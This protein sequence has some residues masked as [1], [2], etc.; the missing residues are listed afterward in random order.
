LS[1]PERS[2]SSGRSSPPER[3]SSAPARAAAPVEPAA[4]PARPAHQHRRTS[5][6]DHEGGPSKP[7]SPSPRVISIGGSGVGQPAQTESRHAVGP[8]RTDT[9]T[10]RFGLRVLVA[11]ALVAGIAGGLAGGAFAG[12]AAGGGGRTT[13]ASEWVADAA[14]R[15]LPS[16]VTIEVR[17][18]E[19]S[20]GSGVIVRSD[21]YI[22]TNRHVVASAVGNGS[23]I[24]VTRYGQLTQ[25]PATLVGQDAKNDLAVIRIDTDGPLPVAT[26]GRSDKLRVG[27]AV[28]AVGAPLGLPG[29]VSAGIVSALNR[30]PSEPQANGGAILLTG[31]IQTDAAINPGSSGG[32]LLGD[33]GRVV[34]IITAIGAVPGAPGGVDS[35][36]GN[37]GVGFS[38]PIERARSVADK[39]IQ[40]GGA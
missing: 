4:R 27:T 7:A 34:G 15:A 3:A 22:L 17:G 25:I 31:A 14:A 39:I 28:I 23:E 29:S 21:G 9:G 18:H 38:I 10:R 32:P 5:A 13:E 26:L 35:Q 16:V 6:H 8:E 30:S 40:S 2:T 12:W 37:I 36:T 1:S 33:D 19:G 11:V 20:T 24:V